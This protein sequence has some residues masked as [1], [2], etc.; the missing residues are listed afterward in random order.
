[1]EQTSSPARSGKIQFSGKAGEFF[2]IWIVNLLLSIVTL[3]IY[4]AWAKVRTNQYFYGH[5]RI[6]Q[7]PFRYLA[8]PIQILKGRIIAVIIFASYAVISSFSPQLSILL[9]LAVLFASPWFIVLSLKFNMRMTSYRNVRFAF[10]GTYGSAFKYCVLF[11]VLSVFTLYLALPWVMKRLDQFIYSNISYGGKKVAVKTEAGTYYIA[12]LAA[13][14]ATF[15]AIMVFGIVASALGFSMLSALDPAAAIG[16][17][18]TGILVLYFVAFVVGTAIYQTLIRNHLFER[19]EFPDVAS[20]KSTVTVPAYLWL[21][22]SNLLA[23]IC[24]LGLAY[25]WVRV[26]KA[27]YL[28]SVTDVTI[29]PQ[30]DKLIDEV[31]QQNNAFGEEAAGLFDIDISIA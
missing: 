29:Y 19:C 13:V 25:P 9:A 31:Q 27:A 8:T 6:D 30:A 2:G 3:G 26:R 21:T 15:G 14:A 17:F 23:I 20:F 1:M 11:P 24:T 28:A 22:A 5:T 12:T 10:H 4:S 16:T 18:I 7:Q